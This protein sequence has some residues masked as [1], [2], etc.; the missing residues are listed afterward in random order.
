MQIHPMQFIIMLRDEEPHSWRI[1]TNALIDT[2][3]KREC[4]KMGI[5]KKSSRDRQG[6]IEEASHCIVPVHQS[7]IDAR[8]Q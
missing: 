5:G 8:R 1:T 7:G 4:R 6:K 3:P 2:S